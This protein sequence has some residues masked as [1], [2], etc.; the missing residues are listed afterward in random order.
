MDSWSLHGKTALVCGASSGI[1]KATALLLAERGARIIALARTEE[2]LQTLMAELLGEGHQ[3]YV[4]DLANTEELTTF[5]PELK[6]E[7]IQIL[8]NN[9]GG[10]KAGLLHEAQVDEFTA[11]MKAHLYAAHLLV[12]TVLPAMKA[13]H[14]GRILNVISTSVKNPLPNL[15]VSNTVRGAM[16]SWSKTLAA[17]LAPFAITVNNVLPGYIK[18]D[19][20]TSLLESAAKN[21]QTSLKQVEES[22]EK[23]VP[24]GRI[25]EPKEMAEAIAFLASPAAS[26]ITGINLPV[27]GGRTPSL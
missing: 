15:G 9:A 21:S 1:G 24:L 11:P 26:Y 12:Q 14:Y 23:T 16:A 17:E 20:L 3:Y 6:K 27:D 18:T 8:I 13:S 2:K 10:P 7:N 25:G 22:W 4:V 19:R 5:L